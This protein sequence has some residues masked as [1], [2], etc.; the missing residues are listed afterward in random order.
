MKPSHSGGRQRHQASAPAATSSTTTPIQVPRPCG[1]TPS[2]PRHPH[3]PGREQQPERLGEGDAAAGQARERDRR[4]RRRR[5]PQYL[6][7][8]EEAQRDGHSLRKTLMSRPDGHLRTHRRAAPDDR[9]LL[10]GGPRAPGHPGVR[11]RHHHLPP[12]GR[13]RGGARRGRHLQPRGPARAAGA[14][15]RPPAGRHLDVRVLLRARRRARPV[16]GR[17]A[18]H[19]SLPLLPPL[20]DR[21]RRARPR[22]APGRPVAGAGARARGVADPLRLLAADRQPAEL[23]PDRAAARGLPVAEVQARRHPGLGPGR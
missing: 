9:R 5:Q 6:D 18:G 21:E 23:R 2:E 3:E 19:A 1:T 22:A 12:P 8:H 4:Q 17:G 16:R 10:A 13:R 20:G 14:R 11:A 7:Q 15:P